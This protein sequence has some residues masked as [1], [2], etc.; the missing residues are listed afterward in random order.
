MFIN[1][2]HNCAFQENSNTVC[3]N[4]FCVLE[5][6]TMKFLTQK[7]PMIT[8]IFAALP[9]P[10]FNSGKSYFKRIT[11][12]TFQQFVTTFRK[13]LRSFSKIF[14]YRYFRDR[15]LLSGQPLLSYREIVAKRV[16]PIS[17]LSLISLKTV[18]LQ[19]VTTHIGRKG[20]TEHS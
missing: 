16:T 5:P 20:Q 2:R 13:K 18:I 12:F 6:Q 10:N 7:E 4:K 8:Q 9:S 19:S 1:I 14:R 15:I 11:M 3:V 17:F